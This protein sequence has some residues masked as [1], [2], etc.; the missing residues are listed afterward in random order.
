MLLLLLLLL[1]SPLSV[2]LLLGGH[3]HAPSCW[4]R[5]GKGDGRLGALG[6][7]NEKGEGGLTESHAAGVE[8][9]CQNL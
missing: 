4:F 3:G 2:E 9:W 1:L 6:T 7:P 8:W 5:R